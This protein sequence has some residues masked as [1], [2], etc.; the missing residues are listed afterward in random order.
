MSF[1]KLFLRG[2]VTLWKSFWFG[3]F[4]SVVELFC[5]KFG[6]FIMPMPSYR[7]SDDEAIVRITLLMIYVA[8][9]IPF[10]YGT[11]KSANKY[12]GQ[13]IWAICAKLF[14]GLIFLVILFG[15]WV[16]GMTLFYLVKY[17]N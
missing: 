7:Y 15:E 1:F 11:W 3:S 13:T 9:H 8:V 12:D 16:Q 6:H 10:L 4:L 17:F 2:E 5:T 14:C